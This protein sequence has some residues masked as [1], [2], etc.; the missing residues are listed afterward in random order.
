VAPLT[1]DEEELYNKLA[2]DLGDFQKDA[3][4]HA[5]RHPGN[6]VIVCSL[7]TLN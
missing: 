7:N 2:F 3:G 1:E 4:V 6:K 5:L